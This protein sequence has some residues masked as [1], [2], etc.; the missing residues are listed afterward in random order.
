MSITNKSNTI[1]TSPTLA[2]LKGEG[3]IGTSYATPILFL[4]FNRPDTTQKVFEKIMAIKPTKLYLAV[5][6][7]RLHKAGEYEKCEQVKQLI[8]N[9]I[10]W[11]CEVKT[12]FRTENI[13]CKLAVSQAINWFFEHEEQGIILEDDCVPDLSFF[14]FCAQLL[15]FYKFDDKVMHIG[16]NNFQNG[17]KRGDGSYYFSNLNHIWGWATWKRAWKKYDIE[18]KK[19]KIFRNSDKF[20]CLFPDK[21][22]INYYDNLINQVIDNQFDTWDVQ[23]TASIWINDGISILPNNNLVSN[24]GFGSDG[25]HTKNVKSKMSNISTNPIKLPLKILTNILVDNKADTF[26]YKNFIYIS[27]FATVKYKIKTLLRKIL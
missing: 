9:N 20:S 2:L 4:I 11:E 24:I 10:D 15:E 23:W 21:K 25:T 16:G 14:D 5:D 22:I 6:G 8:L 18:L 19:W 12:L 17:I 26:F 7:H 13:G 27:T 3:I 1:S